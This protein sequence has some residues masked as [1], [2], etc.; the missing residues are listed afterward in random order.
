MTG[1]K[2]T[3]KQERLAKALRDNLRRRKAAARGEADDTAAPPPESSK[4]D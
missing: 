3:E 1:V 4:R 2:D